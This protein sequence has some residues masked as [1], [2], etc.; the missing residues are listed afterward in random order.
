MRA[1]FAKSAAHHSA[2]YYPPK[3]VSQSRQMP[4]MEISASQTN[5]MSSLVKNLHGITSVMMHPS[6]MG[7]Q[8]RRK[9]ILK[10]F[11]RRAA[12]SVY[13]R[14]RQENAELRMNSRS[15]EAAPQRIDGRPRLAVGCSCKVL[16]TT[17]DPINSTL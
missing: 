15:G 7:I 4:L 3:I 11:C 14:F 17:V 8:K 10:L 13:R 5:P 16:T 2:R 6:T 12:K 9:Q 1:A